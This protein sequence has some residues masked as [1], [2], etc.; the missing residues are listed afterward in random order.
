MN[1]RLILFAKTPRLGSVKTRLVPTLEAGEALALYE[2]FLD[3]QVRFVASLAGPSRR[4]EVATDEPW[5]MPRARTGTQD[6]MEWCLQGPGDLGER[7]IRAFRRCR[8]QG[9]GAT[10]IIGADSPTLPERIV[11]DAFTRLARGAAAVVSP[12][13][14]GGYVLIGM[15]E[16]EPELFR[17]VPWGSAKVLDATRARA[18]D[19]G[20]RLEELEAWY[21]VDDERGLARL[22][23]DLARDPARAPATVFVLDALDAGRARVL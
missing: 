14:D 4:I 17:E 21:D 9:A 22:R 6:R 11:L 5:E 3:D 1:E 12:A 8:A 13:E 18:M 16:A 19:A 10:V 20:L 23:G 7:M 15:T 2:A